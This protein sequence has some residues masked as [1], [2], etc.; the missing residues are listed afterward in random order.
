[1]IGAAVRLVGAGA[2]AA[3]AGDADSLGGLRNYT[4]LVH[5]GPDGVV[6]LHRIAPGS[7]GR[8]YGIHVA[9]LAGLPGDVL[10]RAEEVLRELEG[11]GGENQPVIVTPRHDGAALR[12]G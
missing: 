4:V 2:D 9:R 12:A 10:A 3:D 1:V 6:F 5:E 11:A 8:S 7:A